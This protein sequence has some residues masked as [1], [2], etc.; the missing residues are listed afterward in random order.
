MSDIESDLFERLAAIQHTI[1]AHWQ[2]YV[3]SHK[4]RP[5]ANGSGTITGHVVPVE[6][7]LHWQRQINTPYAE[8]SEKE[9]E[10]DREQV[11]KFWH[12]IES[13]NRDLEA[14]VYIP[15]VQKCTKCVF[16]VVSTNLHVLSDTFSPN[17]DPQD[18]PNGC[19]PLVRVKYKDDYDR[20]GD[21]AD[22]LH[23]LLDKQDE[24]IKDLEANLATSE[25]DCAIFEAKVDELESQ[26]IK[27]VLAAEQALNLLMQKLDA[28]GAEIAELKQKLF[29]ERERA[30]RFADQVKHEI[31]N[32]ERAFIDEFVK[33]WTG[34]D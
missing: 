12:L 28:A 32:K 25:K 11:E 9:K 7:Y 29:L 5:I 10:S 24:H 33:W 26:H 3:H 6:D 16:R 18:C 1:W 21:T 14:D 19:G 27:E 13:A 15:G 20:E 17:D 2:E 8:L 30:D 4:M 22:R 23:K 31:T 34:H